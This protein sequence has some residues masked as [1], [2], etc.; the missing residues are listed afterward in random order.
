MNIQGWS[1][2]KG[3]WYRLFY[4]KLQ[5]PDA[6][7]YCVEYGGHLVSILSEEE[8]QYVDK[9]SKA[10]TIWIG[11]NKRNSPINVYKWSD[12]SPVHYLNWYSTQPNEP[13]AHCVM[14][15]TH[16]SWFDQSCEGKEPL[17][18]VCKLKVP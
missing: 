6:E 1:L 15:Q 12:H 13:L 14:M 10:N 5:W 17:N 7:Q 3:H 4:E 8:N 18:F 11:L 9:L 2:Y 16:S